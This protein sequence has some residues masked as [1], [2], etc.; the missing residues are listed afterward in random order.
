MKLKG[1]QKIEFRKKS[2]KDVITLEDIK[3]FNK[4]FTFSAGSTY[5]IF[6]SSKLSLKEYL[7]ADLKKISESS[8]GVIF[9]II[10]LSLGFLYCYI[11]SSLILIFHSL[12]NYINDKNQIIQ[13]IYIVSIVAMYVFIMIS[14]ESIGK[15]NGPN[16]AAWASL[17]FIYVPILVFLG[18][19]MKTSIFFRKKADIKYVNSNSGF[20]LNPKIND[21]YISIATQREHGNC[22]L[23]V[24]FELAFSVYFI[25]YS[26]E[27]VPMIKLTVII[28]IL[29]S[30]VYFI[31]QKRE[32]DFVNSHS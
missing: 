23:I 22:V 11:A 14:I 6:L 13:G 15:T 25:N 31:S 16:Q 4:N 32:V 9:F 24:L 3:F 29:S 5:L 2:I 26:S 30:L 8:N 12:R 17:Y 28:L 20:S 10:I 7:I 19:I 21:E 18:F 1:N 27:L